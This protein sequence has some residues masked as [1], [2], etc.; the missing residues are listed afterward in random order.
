MNK[1]CTRSWGLSSLLLLAACTPSASKIQKAISLTQ[2]A[3]TPIPTQTA[4]PTY[5]PVQSPTPSPSPTWPSEFILPTVNP[6]VLIQEYMTASYHVIGLLQNPYAP[7]VL[8][9]VTERAL[10]LCDSPDECRRYTDDTHCGSIYTSPTC[11]FFVEAMPAF[12]VD[13]APR[14]VA[15]WSGIMA[16]L[17]IE[18]IHFLNAQEVE[19][20]ATGGDAMTMVKEKYKLD[21]QTGEITTEESEWIE[22]TSTP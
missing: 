4:Y 7:Y 22:T 6:Q 2:A 11:Y 20:R 5:T 17:R 15:T 19:F 21:L 12:G 14:F 9:I 13:P 18:S 16:S 1:S 10:I 3:W 8:I